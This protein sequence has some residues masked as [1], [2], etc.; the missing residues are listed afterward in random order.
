MKRQNL[1]SFLKWTNESEENSDSVAECYI[2]ANRRV[3]SS[4]LTQNTVVSLSKAFNPLLNAGA[5][6]EALVEK[7]PS[8][9]EKK[10]WT[11][12]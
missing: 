5:T 2:W 4:G 7:R 3:A 8:M 9:T 12:T 1:N 6:K 10:L 11:G